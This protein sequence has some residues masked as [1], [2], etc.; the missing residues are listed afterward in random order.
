M[1]IRWLTT[2]LTTMRMDIQLLSP[3]VQEM[4][5][6][7]G[8]GLLGGTVAAGWVWGQEPT[9]RPS[10]REGPRLL[11]QLTGRGARSPIAVIPEVRSSLMAESYQGQPPMS[12]T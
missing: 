4:L 1:A 11:Q 2:V 3:N 9:E 5:T 10:M 12:W 6:S 8:G 7:Q